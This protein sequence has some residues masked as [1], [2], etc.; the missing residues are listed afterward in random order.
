MARA[1]PDI[2]LLKEG[3]VAAPP[4]L[5]LCRLLHSFDRWLDD[6]LQPET[7]TGAKLILAAFA[8]ASIIAERHREVSTGKRSRNLTIEVVNALIRPWARPLFKRKVLKIGGGD[9]DQIKG[10][11]HDPA[12]CCQQQL[13]IK[14]LGEKL[15][16]SDCL[17]RLA[18]FDGR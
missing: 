15:I 1:D 7:I 14:R 5:S 18:R 4:L 6:R 11:Q 3:T 13:G 2:K 16:N 17:T 10:W 9:L 8:Q 12:H